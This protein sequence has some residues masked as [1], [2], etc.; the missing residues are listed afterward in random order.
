MITGSNHFGLA[1]IY[2]PRLTQFPKLIYATVVLK[3]L[4]QNL[5]IEAGAKND[6]IFSFLEWKY[7]RF[8]SV[9]QIW[10]L[11]NYWVKYTIKT[12]NLN[13]YS[14]AYVTHDIWKSSQL[15]SNGIAEYTDDRYSISA[16]SPHQ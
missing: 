16:A 12:N 4:L 5:Y 11:L 2:R 6:L 7:R 3:V 8:L 1:V 15:M 13:K 10:K 14:D 9:T